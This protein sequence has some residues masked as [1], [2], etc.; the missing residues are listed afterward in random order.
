MSLVLAG[1]RETRAD[2]DLSV[3]FLLWHTDYRTS[4]VYL[5][6]GVVME[7]QQPASTSLQFHCGEG[8]EK[9]KRKNPPGWKSLDVSRIEAVFCSKMSQ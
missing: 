2:T 5:G 1:S 8:R 7:K 3:G 6:G 4:W 9:R